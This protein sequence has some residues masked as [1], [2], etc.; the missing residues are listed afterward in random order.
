VEKDMKYENWL[1]SKEKWELIVKNI[2]NRNKWDDNRFYDVVV[3]DQCGY[4]IEY[5]DTLHECAP[6]PL[7]KQ[8]L[9][10][11]DGIEGA[12]MDVV[13]S[14]DHGDYKSALPL[15]KKILDFIINDEPAKVTD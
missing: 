15:A 4:C 1:S 12:F 14:L 5:Y 9:C 13:V 8:N 3:K 10:D 6:C 7:P 2:R 11:D